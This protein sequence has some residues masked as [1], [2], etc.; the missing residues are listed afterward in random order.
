M[1]MAGD[2]HPHGYWLDV[3]PQ[4]EC[5]R[6]HFDSPLAEKLLDII[7]IG[8]SISDLG[9]GNGSYVTFFNSNGRFCVGYDGNP[10]AN[11]IPRC[12]VMDLSFDVNIPVTD[13]VLSLEVAEH[14]PK[15]A[16][17]NFLGN[18]HRHNREGIILS[19]AIPVVGQGY[20]HVNEQPNAYVREKICRMG[21][22]N[23]PAADELVRQHAHAAWFH[24]SVCI[25]RRER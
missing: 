8:K 18:C 21:Y 5:H 7:P 10:N 6:H 24:N 15:W 9:C 22:T 23:N 3:G 12:S 25:F 13:W 1:G 14:I 19:W 2:I 16:E 11:L 4:S 17:D 20:G